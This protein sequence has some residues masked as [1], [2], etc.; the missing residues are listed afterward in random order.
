MKKMLA[1]TVLAIAFCSLL[2]LG[3][4]AA[5]TECAHTYDS[6]IVTKDPTC[7]DSGELTYTCTACGEKKTEAIDKID[8]MYKTATVTKKPT[9]TE[10]GTVTYTCY[11]CN[12]TRTETVEKRHTYHSTVEVKADCD[13]KGKITFKCD[14]GATADPQET[15]YVHDFVSVVTTEPTHDTTGVLTKTCTICNATETEVLP[16]KHDQTMVTAMTAPSCFFEGSV[17]Y[18][19][20]LCNTSIT[21]TIAVSHSY[22]SKI[23]TPA[24]C[25]TNGV[26]RHTCQYCMHSHTDIIVASHDY[27]GGVSRIVYNDYT[28]TGVKYIDCA[29][30]CGA[31]EG[32]IANPIFIFTGYSATAYDANANN[33][34]VEIT[35]GYNV[36]VDALQEFHRVMGK[37]KLQYG[38]VGAV[39]A[40]LGGNDVPPLVSSTGLPVVVSTD[41]DDFIV[42]RVTLG[43]NTYATVNGKLINIDYNN[44]TTYFYLCMYIYDGEKTV[45]IS[46][47][48]CRDVPLPISYSMLVDGTTDEEGGTHDDVKYNTFMFGDIVYSTINGTMPTKARLDVIASSAESYKKEEATSASRNDEDTVAAI[49]NLGQWVG[50]V[51]NANKLLNYYLELGGDATHYHKLDVASLVSKN[52]VAK[53]SWQSSINNI[54]RAAELMAIAGETVNIDQT[55]ETEVQLNSSN[56]LFSSNR[57]WYLSFID[58]FYYTDTDLNNLTVTVDENGVKTY[59]AE[60]VYTVIDYYSFQAWKNSGDTS[61]FLLW[62]PT[63]KELAQLH[64]DGN[65]LDFLIESTITYSVTWTSGQRIARDGNFGDYKDVLGVDESVD[66]SILTQVSTSADAQ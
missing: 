7:Q 34:L 66:A 43:S 54:L 23:T 49:G 15:D 62:G 22:E 47:D 33:G 55:T 9:C 39:Q 60:I 26:L 53:S 52:S 19:C 31:S 61:S 44:H 45:Y 51:P 29:N 13:T 11:M 5:T 1:I 12:I 14:C 42:K 8:H 35:C 64:L 48:S 4:G 18:F 2:S 40:H 20:G 36:D 65:A 50:T 63:R 25:T 17:T 41:T 30:N 10:N 28:S 58:G 57:D 56:S 27:S 32:V 6:G 46:D 21:E 16:V 59:K 24:T 37:D 3:I 38:I